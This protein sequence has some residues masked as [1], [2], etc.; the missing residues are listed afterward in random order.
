MDKNILLF[1]ELKVGRIFYYAP[2]FSKKE[3]VK[4]GEREAISSESGGRNY[5]NYNDEIEIEESNLPL[6]VENLVQFEKD[7]LY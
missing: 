1:G 5:F 4:T 7:F 2:K 3:F 6:T